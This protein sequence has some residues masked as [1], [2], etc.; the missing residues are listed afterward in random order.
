MRILTLVYKILHRG[1]TDEQIPYYWKYPLWTIVIKP[2]RKAFSAIIIPAIPFN[3]IRVVMY[4]LCGYKIGGG[5][6]FIGMRCY[7]D[8]MCYENIEIGNNVVISYGV[9]FACHGKN[10]RHHKIVIRDGAYI[11][12]R[13]MIIARKDIEIGE[14]AIIGAGTLIN[15]SVPA[16]K[17][18]VGVP[19]RILE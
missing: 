11:G 6:G 12:M 1:I 7:L 2:V 9:Y 10:Q 14:N 18:A 19:C 17:T 15:K 13:A 4:R 3:S 8:D 5:G 16:N